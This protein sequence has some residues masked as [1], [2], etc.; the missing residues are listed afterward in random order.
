MAKTTAAYF[1]DVLCIWAYVAQARIDELN[2]EFGSSVQVDHRFCSVFGDTAQKVGVAWK[3][4][5][6]YAGYNAHVR[7]VAERYPHVELA[8][9]LWLDV[10]PASSASPH[11]FLAA[12]RRSHLERNAVLHEQAAWA[13]RL[14]F[15]RDGR[16]ISRLETQRELAA[17]LG[18]DLDAVSRCLMDGGAHA[19]LMSD[20]Q[21]AEKLHIEGSPTLVLNDGRQKLFGNVGYRIIQANVQELLRVGS[22]EEASWC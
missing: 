4:K 17:P 1:T 20:Y 21:Q 3:D 14:A 13:F 12:I 8:A 22:A 15:F 9:N 11:L 19:E 5:G 16:D 2:K 18:V 10:R 6:G 7:A